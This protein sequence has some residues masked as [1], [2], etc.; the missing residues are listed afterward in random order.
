MV[1]R[2]EFST[3]RTLTLLSPLKVCADISLRSKYASL[4]TPT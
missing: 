3:D 2:S 1:A 4:S